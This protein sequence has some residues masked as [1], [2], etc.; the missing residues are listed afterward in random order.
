MRQTLSESDEALR[1][2]QMKK[3]IFELTKSDLQYPWNLYFYLKVTTDKTQCHPKNVTSS[4]VVVYFKCDLS[5][6][7]QKE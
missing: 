6:L 1:Q 4:A 3:T 5:H 2:F 7:K